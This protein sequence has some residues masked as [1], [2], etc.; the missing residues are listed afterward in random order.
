MKRVF[1][2]SLFAFLCSLCAANGEALVKVLYFHSRM[3]CKTCMAIES[4][5]KKIL[6]EFF[7]KELKDG[8]LA[9]ETIDISKPCNEKISDKYRIAFSPLLVV[10]NVGSKE[11]IADFTKFAFATAASKPQVYRDR[12]IDVLKKAI[13]TSKK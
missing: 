7:S 1:L 9:F 3:R 6:D 13:E 12:L 10:N 2:F 5:T 8:S 4:E 11:D